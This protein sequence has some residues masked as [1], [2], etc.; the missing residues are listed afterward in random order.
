MSKWTRA[1]MLEHHGDVRFRSSLVPQ[2]GDDVQ[3][4]WATWH[5][6]EGWT[7]NTEADP[8]VYL[9]AEGGNGGSIADGK[10]GA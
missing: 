10:D 4:A 7:L 6:R 8:P 1:G 3:K 5:E 2:P 9:K